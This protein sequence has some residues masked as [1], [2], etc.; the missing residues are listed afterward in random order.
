MVSQLF[1]IDVLLVPVYS[2]SFVSVFVL[3]PS[4]FVIDSGLFVWNSSM[5][6]IV[7]V[8]FALVRD[9]S[10]I[11]VSVL[12]YVR[13][14]FALVLSTNIP[15]TSRMDTNH[16]KNAVRTCRMNYEFNT[17]SN[18][19]TFK[20]ECFKQQN[21]FVLTP[22]TSKNNTNNT[23]IN[24]NDLEWVGMS[25]RTNKNEHKFQNYDIRA[26]FVLHIRDSVNGALA[27]SSYVYHFI[28]ICEFKLE[29]QSGNAQ[30]GSNSTIFRA[31]WPWNL[32]N[33]LEKQ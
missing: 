30:S 27:I 29:L 26:A 7:R 24:T 16:Y 20:Y 33:D 17:N 10:W 1:R 3:H 14:A 21:T 4:L 12:Y 32:T 2:C 9:D 13:D 18:W 11:F 28:I 8:A 5:V 31:V 19:Y 23:R 22:R 25:P 6:V 15:R